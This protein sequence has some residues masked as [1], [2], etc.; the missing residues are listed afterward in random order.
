MASF[1]G[2][3]AFEHLIMT[4]FTDDERY[5]LI[6][7][8]CITN[9]DSP[10][11]HV[12]SGVLKIRAAVLPTVLYFDDHYYD[13][14][15][16]V[17]LSNVHYEVGIDLDIEYLSFRKSSR[18]FEGCLEPREMDVLVVLLGRTLSSKE[19]PVNFALVLRRVE[20]SRDR[21]DRIGNVEFPE[22]EPGFLNAEIRTIENV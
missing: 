9:T 8:E 3:T 1:E 2:R 10:F 13:P 21:Y 6:A 14:D 11:G 4:D 22:S 19:A 18:S 17:I 15:C 5:G 12:T 16:L 7:A 20:A